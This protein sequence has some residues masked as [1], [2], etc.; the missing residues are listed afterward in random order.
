MQLYIRFDLF[1][2]RLYQILTA[3]LLCSDQG[4]TLTPAGSIK[5]SVIHHLHSQQVSLVSNV[6]W[7]IPAW[8]QTPHCGQASGQNTQGSWLQ[9]PRECMPSHSAESVLNSKPES[10]P[11]VWPWRK[12]RLDLVLSRQ[13]SPTWLHFI[14]HFYSSCVFVKSLPCQMKCVINE[15]SSVDQWDPL[16][17]QVK[18]QSQTSWM[19]KSAWGQEM[20]RKYTHKALH[21]E[22]CCPIGEWAIQW[23][24]F[25]A[26]IFI[27]L[28]HVKVCLKLR[29]EPVPVLC[30]V[31]DSV[32]SGAVDV[33]Q[34]PL[35]I[36]WN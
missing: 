32:V 28:T 21:C 33:C 29:Q 10:H 26:H 18:E 16:K 1:L 12:K 17:E 22:A 34:D 8:V 23:S 27:W 31:I 13:V 15:L 3:H 11:Q 4:W 30:V 24:L 7:R 36:L 2:F 6:T 20:M 35:S 25:S 5:L 9:I 14:C 19:W